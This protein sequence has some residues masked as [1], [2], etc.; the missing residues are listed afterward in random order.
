MYI[1]LRFFVFISEMGLTGYIMPPMPSTLPPCII[2]KYPAV[3]FL[4]DYGCGR[5]FTI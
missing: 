3:R 1:L 4:P 5:G 2:F